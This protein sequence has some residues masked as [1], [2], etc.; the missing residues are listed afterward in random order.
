MHK[1]EVDILKTRLRVTLAKFRQFFLMFVPGKKSTG[2][3]KN[4]P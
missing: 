3:Y 2:L 1:N 4:R